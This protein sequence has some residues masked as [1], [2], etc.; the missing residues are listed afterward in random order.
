MF[1]STVSSPAWMGTSMCGIT[2]GSDATQSIS[3]AVIQLGCEVR[4]RMRSMPSTSA[5]RRINP[6]SEG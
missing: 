6:A 2:L 1:S 3:S 4:K 5:I